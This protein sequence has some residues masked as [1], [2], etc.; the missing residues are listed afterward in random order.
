MSKAARNSRQVTIKLL[1]EFLK[2]SVNLEPELEQF[3]KSLLLSL[4]FQNQGAF[5]CLQSLTTV[6]IPTLI[7]RSSVYINVI[8]HVFLK[9]SNKSLAI[10]C[11]CYV[12]THKAIPCNRKGVWS[13][14]KMET[15]NEFNL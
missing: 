8:R 1:R 3:V 6:Q 10:P 14:S 4:E 12:S 15:G 13:M 2:E 9:G 5:R 7:D 11:H